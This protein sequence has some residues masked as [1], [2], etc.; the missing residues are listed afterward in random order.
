MHLLIVI[1]FAKVSSS[2]LRICSSVT[3]HAATEEISQSW[4]RAVCRPFHVATAPTGLDPGD[5]RPESPDRPG[6]APAAR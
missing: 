6:P 1:A 3:S 4:C 5:R 2:N